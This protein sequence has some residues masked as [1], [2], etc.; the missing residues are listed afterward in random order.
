M[1]SISSSVRMGTRINYLEGIYMYSLPTC[2]HLYLYMYCT[3]VR[4]QYLAP[5]I[6]NLKTLF[7]FE[8]LA[9]VGVLYMYKCTR[10]VCTTLVLLVPVPGTRTGKM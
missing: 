10:C 8:G 9:T 3:R 7:T 4:V 6:K 1:L 2:V 5:G